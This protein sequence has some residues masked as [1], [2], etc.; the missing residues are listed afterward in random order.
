MARRRPAEQL[1]FLGDSKVLEPLDAAGR[2]IEID[3][4]V[5]FD[6]GRS[7]VVAKL[8]P[9]NVT[10]R[11]RS[12]SGKWHTSVRPHAEVRMFRQSDFGIG[13]RG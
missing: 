4:T 10:I 12:S 3:R 5:L 13:Y 11:W 1:S 6:D 8:G 7:G 9:R 2:R